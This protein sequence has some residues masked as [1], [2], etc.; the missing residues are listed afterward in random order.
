MIFLAGCGRTD[1]P[2]G[3]AAG[4][5]LLVAAAQSLQGAVEVGAEAFRARHPGVRIVWTYGASGV[6]ARQIDAGAPIDILLSA[7]AREMDWAEQRGLIF[8][9]SRRVLARNRLVLIAAESVSTGTLG[10]WEDL[11]RESVG[12]VAL[13][14]PRTV[15]AGQ[16]ADEVLRRLG[17]REAITG[18]VVY[19]ANVRQVLDYVARGEVAAG[20]VYASDVRVARRPVRVVA[21]APAGTHSPIEYPMAVVRRSSRPEL[22]REFL[23]VL[24]SPGVQASLEKAGFLAG[25]EGEN[26]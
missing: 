19:G 18:K 3:G 11:R 26:R 15:P 17:L 7:S 10:S 12:R 5:E 9:D 21:E 8:A 20:V 2:A 23:D 1:A 4:G 16:Y 6:L 24:G 13:G 14:D 25:G 22:A